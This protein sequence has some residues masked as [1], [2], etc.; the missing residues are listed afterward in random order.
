MCVHACTSLQLQGSPAARLHGLGEPLKYAGVRRTCCDRGPRVR[1]IRSRVTGRASPHQQ[2]QQ[3]CSAGAQRQSRPRCHVSRDG[4]GAQEASLSWPPTEALLR[5]RRGAHASHARSQ[6]AGLRAAPEGPVRS[7]AVERALHRVH[8]G[9]GKHLGAEAAL[10]GVQAHG[11]RG[12][13]HEELH[14]ALP[15]GVHVAQVVAAPAITKHG[16]EVGWPGGGEDAVLVH[17]GQP[18]YH[19][20]HLPLAPGIRGHPLHQVVVGEVHGEREGG[21]FE[22]QSLG[23]HKGIVLVRAQAAAHDEEGGFR[24]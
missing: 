24:A 22:G 9:L 14:L 10:G 20:V 1:P 6:G 5:P 12:A 7:L 8:G 4:E 16:C 13:L 18:V 2:Q 3:Q 11:G 15:Q 19:V 21:P 17:L 23:G